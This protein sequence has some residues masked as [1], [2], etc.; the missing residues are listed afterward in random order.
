MRGSR[1]NVE[2]TVSIEDNIDG[3]TDVVENV[4]LDID[5]AEM[6]EELVVLLVIVEK[7]EP[8]SGQ[9]MR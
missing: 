4:E 6:V 1:E 7:C 5:N 2:V 9:K 3:G 8:N